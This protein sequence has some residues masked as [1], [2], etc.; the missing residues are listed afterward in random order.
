MNSYK[1]AIVQFKAEAIQTSDDCTSPYIK[2]M[3]CEKIGARNERTIL[4][5]TY[6]NIHP[7]SVESL[8]NTKEVS[9]NK[10]IERISRKISALLNTFDKVIV[11][12]PMEHALVEEYISREDTEIILVS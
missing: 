12:S 1:V 8:D 3:R 7:K 2:S 10:K 6:P 9:C 4:D 11:F 5:I